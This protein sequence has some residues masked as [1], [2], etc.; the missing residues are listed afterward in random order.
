MAAMGQRDA[1]LDSSMLIHHARTR[2]KINSFFS[3]SLL[4]YY[5]NLSV[6]SIYEIE[7]GAFRARR[8]S[9]IEA[10]QVSF[11]ILPLTEQIARRAA[12]LEA[13]L[14]HRNMQIGIKDTFIAATCLVYDLPLLTVN[15]RHFDRVEGL[16]L[17]D[18]NTLPLI[19]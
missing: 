17:I 11:N 10:L 7:F 14:V 13:S 2:N 1:I 9:D 18:L 15:I 6:I 19:N 5:P 8:A 16:Q 3:R 12:A 4:V